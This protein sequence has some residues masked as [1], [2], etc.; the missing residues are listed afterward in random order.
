MSTV[1]LIDRTGSPLYSVPSDIS[2]RAVVVF[3]WSGRILLR[4]F[5]GRRRRGGWPSPRHRMRALKAEMDAN[6][7][8]R[9]RER[10]PATPL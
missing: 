3:Y 2:H 1:S 5:I 4:V 10:K 8:E 9:E 6:D 7:A